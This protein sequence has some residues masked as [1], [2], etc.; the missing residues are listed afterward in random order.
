MCVCNLYFVPHH[1][2]KSASTLLSAHARIWDPGSPLSM[3]VPA[4]LPRFGA[5]TKRQAFAGGLFPTN[6]WRKTLMLNQQPWLVLVIAFRK[7]RLEIG[8]RKRKRLPV[9]RCSSDGLE[10]F[11][12][13]FPIAVSTSASLRLSTLNPSPRAALHRHAAFP[14]NEGRLVDATPRTSEK[15]CTK[16]ILPKLA[17]RN[18]ARRRGQGQLTWSQHCNG[19][20]PQRLLN[21]TSSWSRI[22]QVSA[23]TC[24]GCRFASC[25]K[26]ELFGSA[27]LSAPAT[28]ELGSK[29]TPDSG[30]RDILTTL[31]AVHHL[32]WSGAV[33]DG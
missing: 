2:L 14:R 8:T 5:R 1:L 13:Q 25:Q 23:H 21:S 16:R 30:V 15:R 29:I 4:P 18:T 33:G 20:C 19:W 10:G 22:P 24:K 26:R 31:L 27:R 12:F 32:N 17:P 11:S 7:N 3:I 9:L 28:P 6:P